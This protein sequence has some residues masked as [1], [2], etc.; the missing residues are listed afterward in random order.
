[1]EIK[2]YIERAKEQLGGISDNELARRIGVKS[3]TVNYY[4]HGKSWPDNFACLQFAKIL[5]LDP[6]LVILD[7]EAQKEKREERK[8]VW[9]QALIELHFTSRS[10]VTPKVTPAPDPPKNPSKNSPLQSMS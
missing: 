10:P 8:K 9:T 6:Y 2:E 7:L 5:G 3:P 1:M 4:K